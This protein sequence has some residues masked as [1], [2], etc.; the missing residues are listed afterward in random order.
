[1]QQRSIIILGGVL[2][3]Q[4]LL[5]LFLNLSGPEFGATAVSG[6]LL[7]FDREAVDRLRIQAQGQ[8]PLVL[9]KRDGRWQLPGL[10]GFPVAQNRLEELLGRL[11][12]LQRRL[13]V[14]TREEAAKRFKVSPEAYERKLEL[15]AGE[16]VLATLWVGD[17]AGARRAY[18]RQDGDPLIHEVA[19]A[20]HELGAR[21]DDWADPD[22]L[23]LKP[24]DLTQLDL[25]SGLTLE[26]R[27]GTWQVPG[28]AEG[29]SAD[30]GQL[31][32]LARQLANLDF[33]GVLG[34]EPGKGY[35]PEVTAQR[36][37]V[38]LK[39]GERR[40]YDLWKPE[41][42]LDYVLKSSATPYYFR[43][44]T[45]MAREL[46][47]ASRDKLVKVPA[48][49][50]PAPVATSTDQATDQAAPATPGGADPAPVVQVEPAPPVPAEPAPVAPAVEPASTPANQ[51]EPRAPTDAAA[52]AAPP[53][54]EP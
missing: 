16:R 50:A 24:E 19:L 20:T 4:L 18:A 6:P 43:V 28:L 23:H 35:G 39:A 12:N 3:A 14:A 45:A 25:P 32:A 27:E 5:A 10:G 34:Q 48:S 36:V 13:P 41:G 7:S 38:T 8:E 31:A 47:E 51:S 21:G 22:Y 9:E 26:N 37:S 29:E 46:L 11:A 44:S 52:P 40:H 30:G 54:R 53:A 17:S 33:L 2:V 49:A 1:M 42:Q 15:L